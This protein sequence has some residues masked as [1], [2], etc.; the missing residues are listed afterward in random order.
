MW[1]L[2]RTVCSRFFVGLNMDGLV[3]IKEPDEAQ[4][5]AEETGR[6]DIVRRTTVMQYRDRLQLPCNDDSIIAELPSMTLLRFA[7]QLDMHGEKA[8]SEAHKGRATLRR[9]PKARVINMKPFLNLDL[10]GYMIGKHARMAL[11]LLVP[12]QDRADDP[13]KIED[14]EEAVR[15]LESLARDPSTPRWF[16]LRY[17]LH[18]RKGGLF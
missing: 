15:R 12:W 5:Q 11:R 3:G 18:N 16:R 10:R 14:D 13:M 1:Q 7:S 2:P 9:R 4:R 8:K 17:S 6:I